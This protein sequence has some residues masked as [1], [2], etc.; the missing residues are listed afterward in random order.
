ME[1]NYH[2]IKYLND[3]PCAAL[4]IKTVLSFDEK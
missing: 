2:N 3:P 1:I 4:G